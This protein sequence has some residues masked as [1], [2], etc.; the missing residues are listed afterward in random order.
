MITGRIFLP[1]QGFKILILLQYIDLTMD[2]QVRTQKE[3]FNP[4]HH[5]LTKMRWGTLL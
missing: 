4:R 3:T 1:H 2:L 5:F